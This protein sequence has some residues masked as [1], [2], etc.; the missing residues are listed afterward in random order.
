MAETL[1]ELDGLDPVAPIGPDALSARA[2][3]VVMDLVEPSRSSA[4]DKLDEG[5]QALTIA[6]NWLRSK[7]ALEADLGADPMPEAATL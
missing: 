1:V 7:R 5:T 4:L 6:T 2:A 3:V